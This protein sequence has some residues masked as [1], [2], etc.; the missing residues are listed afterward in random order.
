QRSRQAEDRG[1]NPRQTMRQHV[2]SSNST[3]EP[4]DG[5][6]RY[7]ARV[8][9]WEAWFSRGAFGGVHKD[10]ADRSNFGKALSWLK[11]TGASSVPRVE[12]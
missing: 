4:A 12:R 2:S 6:A 11:S 9:G 10:R 1:K 3:A 5:I 7:I 8:R